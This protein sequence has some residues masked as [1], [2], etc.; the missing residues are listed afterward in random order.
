[1]E[2]KSFIEEKLESQIRECPLIPDEVKDEF[3]EKAMKFME[4]H[5]KAQLVITVQENPIAIFEYYKL[6]KKAWNLKI[7]ESLTFSKAWKDKG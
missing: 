4:S 6:A 7:P 5:V 3:V 1:M 2:A